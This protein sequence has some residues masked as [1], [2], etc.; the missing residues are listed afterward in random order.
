MLT[1]FNFAQ[2]YQM[3]KM[4]LNEH[5]CNSK[6]AIWTELTLTNIYWRTTTLN[7]TNVKSHQ[8]NINQTRKTNIETTVDGTNDKTKQAKQY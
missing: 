1:V 8:Y 7:K 2:K 5:K 6:R 4:N 3:N